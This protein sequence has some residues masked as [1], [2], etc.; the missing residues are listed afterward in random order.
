MLAVARLLVALVPLRRWRST[1]G[2]AP[3]QQTPEDKT[4]RARRLAR[5][6]ER[7]AHRLPFE[8]KCLPQAMALSWMLR[9]R[10]IAHGVVIGVRQPA[11]GNSEDTLHA[12]VEIDRQGVLGA[13]TG[14]WQEVL[15]L[16][17]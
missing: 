1:L 8:A 3:G 9:R 11:A 7:A 2:G 16:G 5:H 15:R 4:G 10:R 17:G 14:D 12:W 13:D 6:V